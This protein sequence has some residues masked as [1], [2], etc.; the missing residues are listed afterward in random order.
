MKNRKGLFV[1]RKDPPLLHV[2]NIAMLEL[3]DNFIDTISM[4]KGRGEGGIEGIDS[5]ITIRRRSTRIE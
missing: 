5:E 4:G 3:L 2:G 1:S